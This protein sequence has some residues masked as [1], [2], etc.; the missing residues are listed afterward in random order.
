MRGPYR[1]PALAF[2]T[3]FVTLAFQILA[4]RMVSAKFV[5]N[6]AFLII[7]LTMLGFAAAGAL[8]SRFR[9]AF[10]ATRNASSAS[11]PSFVLTSVGAGA[12][13]ARRRAWM[14][15]LG[16][17]FAVAFLQCI[18]FAL[19]FAL[20]FACC[21]LILLLLRPQYPVGRVYFAD[22][23]GSACGAFAVLPA[24][25]GWGVENSVLAAGA[26]LLLATPLL[27]PPSTHPSRVLVAVTLAT[28]GAA[29]LWKGPVLR[30]RYP[31]GSPLAATQRP[32]S[33]QVLE[34][35]AWDPLARIEVSRVPEPDMLRTPWPS[36]FGPSKNLHARM[37][38]MI[39]QNNNAW[40]Y[41]VKY[42]GSPDTVRGIEETIYA[43]AYRARPARH[44]RVAVLGVGGGFDVVTALFFGASSVVGVEVNAATHDIVTRVYPSTGVPGARTRGCACP[45]ETPLPHGDAGRL[46]SSARASIPRAAR[47]GGAHLRRTPVHG[48]AFDLY[49]SR[50]SDDGVSTS[51]AT[52]STAPVL[53]GLVTAWR[54]AWRGVPIRDHVVTL[55]DE[56]AFWLARRAPLHF[57]RRARGLARTR[58]FR[59]SAA[60][61]NASWRIHQMFWP[62]ME[63]A[64]RL[65][66]YARIS[67]LPTT[68]PSSS[69]TRASGICSPGIRRS[70]RTSPS[71][72]G[73]S[74]CSWACWRWRAPPSSCSP[75]ATSGTPS[76]DPRGHFGWGSISLG[77][78][79][80]T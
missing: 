36:L 60:R 1:A 46:T 33:G 56:R 37:R 41:A 26:L 39:T 32:G 54:H 47:R 29:P 24:I 76:D 68:G 8:L 28:L 20:P 49:L 51:C 72:S 27:F 58:P 9:Q 70:A 57:G 74:S 31:E 78:A 30:L 62:R 17:A 18:L 23:L 43:A 16:A 44:P 71:W 63:P 34:Y 45:D 2:V 73:A 64:S 79:S 48:R 61:R 11:R 65:L 40:T 67:P 7:S 52:S 59:V 10:L 42:D 13:T 5:N 14:G 6:Y 75:S 66:A 38:L 21:G 69:S 12:L 25:S 50:L 55:T 53:R 80:A 35:V 4:H 3:A 15:G 19:L 22:L 77:S